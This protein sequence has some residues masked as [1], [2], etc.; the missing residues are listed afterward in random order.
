MSAMLP[1]VSNAAGKFTCNEIFGDLNGRKAGDEAKQS[2]SLPEMLKHGSP[3]GREE[4]MKVEAKLSEIQ[5]QLKKDFV[6]WDDVVEQ[7]MNASR[8]LIFYGDDIVQKPVVVP[9][10]GFPG[11]GKTTLIQRWQKLM[12]FEDIHI[13]ENIEKN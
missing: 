7:L 1:L 13:Q 3:V 10:L 8:L 2:E 12:G 4:R 11:Y 5:T 9:I 6:G